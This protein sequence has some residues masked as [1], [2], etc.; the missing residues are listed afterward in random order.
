MGSV[1]SGRQSGTQQVSDP[2]SLL[3]SVGTRDT[4]AWEV[5]AG[6]GASGGTI[7]TDIGMSVTCSTSEGTV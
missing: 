5:M 3:M 7:G 1:H 4:S 6:V 2:V